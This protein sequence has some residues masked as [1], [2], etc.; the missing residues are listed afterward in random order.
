MAY[1]SYIDLVNRVTPSLPPL[2]VAHMRPP[3]RLAKLSVPL[4]QA[5]IILIPAAGVHMRTDPPFQFIN[6]TSFR[7][8]SQSVAPNEIRPS[9]PSPIRRPGR[10][11]VNVVFPYQRLAELADEGFVGGPTANHLSMQGAIKSLRY[12]VTEMAPAMA[13]EARQQ[14]ADAALLIPL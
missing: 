1:V 7:L 4:S 12:V 8:L 6:D 11:D 5:R 9:H 10:V 3:E 2:P 13:E 14:G